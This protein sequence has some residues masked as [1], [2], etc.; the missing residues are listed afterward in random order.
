MLDI[1]INFFKRY[2]PTVII[3]T[4]N[5]ELVSTDYL[6]AI[7]EEFE[8]NYSKKAIKKYLNKY[9]IVIDL[10]PYFDLTKMLY[11]YL[12]NDLIYYLENYLKYCD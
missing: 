10:V 11:D 7:F 4:L 2:Y 8:A 3:N 9:V 5:I 1:I 6:I 12:N